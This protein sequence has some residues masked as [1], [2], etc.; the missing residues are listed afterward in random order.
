MTRAADERD[1]ESER[2]RL[3]EMDPEELLSEALRRRA[4][5]GL[6]GMTKG[7]R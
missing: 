4:A 7:K 2:K 1:A 3:A 5:A 6:D